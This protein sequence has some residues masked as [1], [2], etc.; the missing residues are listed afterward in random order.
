M[1]ESLL[2]YVGPIV[3]AA[4]VIATKVVDIVLDLR[5]KRRMKE[6]LSLS[7]KS[8]PDLMRLAKHAKAGLDESELNEAAGIISRSLDRLTEDDRRR[9]NVGLHQ[10]NRLGEA[11]F[12]A[13][14]MTD[15][16]LNQ[17]R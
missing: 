6:T 12:V 8:D 16:D 2:F 3:F 10:G 5:A 1:I 9:I 17:G 15:F 13:S 11:R 4:I 7:V 14:L